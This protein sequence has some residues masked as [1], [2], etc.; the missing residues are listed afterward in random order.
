MAAKL[1]LASEVGLDVSEAF[2]WYE[3]RRA[4]LGEE[5]LSSLDA[6]IARICRQPLSY[7]MVHESYRRALLRRFP[8]AILFESEGLTITIY[9]V[10]HTSR[11]PGKWRQRL[12]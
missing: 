7:S 1:V 3:A 11:E 10:F 12:P 6:A 9:G 4:G 8:D 5:F 2:A